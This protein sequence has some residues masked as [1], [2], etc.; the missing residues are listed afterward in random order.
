[1]HRN[2]L[3]EIIRSFDF[4]KLSTDDLEKIVNIIKEYILNESV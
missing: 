3:I 4:T 2:D 1:M